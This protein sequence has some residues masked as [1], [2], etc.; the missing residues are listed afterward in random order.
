MEFGEGE[1]TASSQDY[2]L[3]IESLSETEEDKL[4]PKLQSPGHDCPSY[5]DKLRDVTENLGSNSTSSSNKTE[6][7]VIMRTNCEHLKKNTDNPQL[8]VSSCIDYSPLNVKQARCNIEKSLFSHG[9]ASFNK[10]SVLKTQGIV[11]QGV[12]DDGSQSSI[13]ESSKPE[14]DS[15]EPSQALVKAFSSCG[16]TCLALADADDTAVSEEEEGGLLFYPH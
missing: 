8:D 2:T 7:T 4:R 5:E 6:S 12:I 15:T 14:T 16:N 1:S 9:V 3:M 11:E 10:K 13:S